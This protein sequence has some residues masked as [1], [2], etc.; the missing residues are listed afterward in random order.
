MK[1]LYRATVELGQ[2]LTRVWHEEGSSSE[3]VHD[4]IMKI[5]DNCLVEWTRIEVELES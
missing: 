3:A 4:N 1:A 2:G 5:L